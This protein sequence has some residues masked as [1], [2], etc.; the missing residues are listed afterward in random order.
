LPHAP[1]IS[2]LMIARLIVLRS[3][4]DKAHL[5]VIF[6]TPV[7]PRPS[8]T[9]IPSS[10]PY[11]SLRVPSISWLFRRT[12]SYYLVSEWLPHHQVPLRRWEIRGGDEEK[13]EGRKEEIRKGTKWQR[14]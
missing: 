8:Q 9:Q 12:I 11:R 10:A 5:Y 13:K 6:S 3:T 4:N 7:W 2:F 14:G 1:P